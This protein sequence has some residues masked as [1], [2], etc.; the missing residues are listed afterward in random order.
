[1]LLKAVT[2]DTEFI[3]DII[4]FSILCSMLN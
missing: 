1:M 3:S 2:E 4:Y